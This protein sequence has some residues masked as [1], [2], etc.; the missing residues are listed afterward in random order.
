MFLLFRQKNSCFLGA[1]LQFFSGCVIVEEAFQRKFLTTHDILELFFKA[2]SVKESTSGNS[3]FFSDI[4]I[5]CEINYEYLKLSK[6]R[7]SAP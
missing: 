3:R 5:L 7:L 2:F 6:T 1:D 4:Q